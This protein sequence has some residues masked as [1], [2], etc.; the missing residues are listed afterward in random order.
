MPAPY[1]LTSGFPLTTTTREPSS[2]SSL[3]QR[4]PKWGCIARSPASR[5]VH[6]GPLDVLP[7][8]SCKN[9]SVPLEIPPRV[10]RCHP[11][12]PNAFLS[13]VIHKRLLR[14]AGLTVT[15]PTNVVRGP[16]WYRRMRN[17][18]KCGG[19]RRLHCSTSF[20]SK[21]IPQKPARP[22]TLRIWLL[23]P[24]R[25]A[26]YMLRPGRPLTATLKFSPKRTSL[27]GNSTPSPTPHTVWLHRLPV[28]SYSAVKAR[29]SA[30]GC[31][32]RF[33]QPH[34]WVSTNHNHSGTE[35]AKV[36]VAEV[37][38]V[39]TPSPE[40]ASGVP[41]GAP[42]FD[43]QGAGFKSTSAPQLVFLQLSLSESHTSSTTS[44]HLLGGACTV[45]RRTCCLP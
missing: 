33:L 3:W 21:V 37:P 28:K 17:H 6:C 39:G 41:V 22:V 13:R 2:P 32:A 19:R 44:V 26:A 29:L 7:P 9:A 34:Q 15:P 5:R 20:L 31:C 11:R 45:V 16:A 14:G 24:V 8:K 43:P 10:Q 1:S 18:H 35:F 25:N 27:A 40:P 36:S 23:F 4:S 30:C 42:A 38:R 12:G